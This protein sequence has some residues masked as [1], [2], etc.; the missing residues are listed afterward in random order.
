MRLSRYF[1]T[2]KDAV[3]DT[4]VGA[5]SHRAAVLQALMV[6]FLWSTSW[7]LI[8]TGLQDI[9]ALT[10]AGLR[11]FL[12]FICLMPFALRSGYLKTLRGMSVAGWGR[13]ILLGVLLITVT[14]GAQFMGLAYLPAVTVNLLF[15]LTTLLVAFLGIVILA[16]RPSILQGRACCRS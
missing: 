1:R 9:P 11:Y 10:F 15:S 16:E 7:V 3:K 4:S 13:L 2:K 6:T 5:G 14:Q 12:A 8:K